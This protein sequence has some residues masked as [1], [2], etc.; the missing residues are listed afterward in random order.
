MQTICSK[1]GCIF[2]EQTVQSLL[3]LLWWKFI[4]RTDSHLFVWQIWSYF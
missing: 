3:T 4:Y 2:E 1:Q